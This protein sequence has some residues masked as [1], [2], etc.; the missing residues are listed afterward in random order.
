MCD[1]QVD[2][3]IFADRLVNTHKRVDRWT[4]TGYVHICIMLLNASSPMCIN[5]QARRAA[6][7]YCKL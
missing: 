7:I 3:T 2:I 5:A 6:R 4:G 1:L